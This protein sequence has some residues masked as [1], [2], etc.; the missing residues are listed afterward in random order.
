IDGRHMMIIVA[1]AKKFGG[2]FNIAPEGSLEDGEFDVVAFGNLG[3]FAR[4]EAMA[5]LIR[6]T[7]NSLPEVSTK[8]TSR[9]TLKFENPPA[10]E[11]DGEWRQAKTST[12][13]IDLLPKA[14]NV[15]V[16]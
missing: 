11:T 3:F 5:G 4:L 16:P 9:L 6:G 14:L 13:E 15:L 7:H 2:G 1:N 8:R 12:V 10:F